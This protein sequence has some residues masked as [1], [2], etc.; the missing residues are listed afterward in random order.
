M[1]Y[2]LE[3]TILKSHAAVVFYTG[4]HNCVD[5]IFKM[6]F[7]FYTQND[8]IPKDEAK[9]LQC[10]ILTTESIITSRKYCDVLEWK[11]SIC[12]FSCL[13]VRN[14]C[15]QGLFSLFLL[16]FFWGGVSNTLFPARSNLVSDLFQYDME[17]LNFGVEECFKFCF[18]DLHDQFRGTI[19]LM[20]QRDSMDSL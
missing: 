8:T 12:S 10:K 19:S 13:H 18:V 5:V 4:T 17:L 2:F 15:H 6:Y 20:K 11:L 9:L 7:V 14:D 1:H 16:F 3:C